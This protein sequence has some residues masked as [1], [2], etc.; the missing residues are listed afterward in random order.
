[1]ST[2]ILPSGQSQTTS[3]SPRR[4]YIATD[5][6]IKAAP[7]PDRYA[8]GWHVIGL[9]KQFQDG[10]PHEL[11]IFGTKLVV[12][13]GE[14]GNLNVLDGYCPHMGAS[15]GKGKIIGN[16]VSCAFHGWEWGG[17]GRC[18]NI[19]FS[20]R[21]PPRAKIK[22]WPTMIASDQLFVY[23]DPE[24]N[25]P[26]PEHAIPS[27]E[28]YDAG[29]CTPWHWE[30]ELMP[31]NC[32]ELIDNNADNTHFYYVHGWMVR[33]FKNIFEGHTSSQI[34]VYDARKDRAL[35][36]G[37][38][39]KNEDGFGMESSATYYG[40]AYMINKQ[41]AN[42]KGHEIECWLINAHYPVTP[43]SFVL[44]VGVTARKVPGLP[45][46][47]ALEIAAEYAKA[48]RNAFFQDVEIWRNKTR[49]DNPLLS[50]HDGP[51]YQLRR[52]YEQFY[53]DVK[54]VQPDMVE[55]FELEV[56]MT[57][58]MKYWESEQAKVHE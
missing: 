34:A 33:K 20:T 3:P 50:E 39:V 15:L 2:P 47:A 38:G 36:E 13:A 9:V 45:E 40:P 49:I 29:E 44:N 18:S 30:T 35:G 11:E 48:F 57:Q 8:R 58:P 56:D 12:F 14:D 7:P 32:R 46:E 27:I 28:A 23:N 16:S 52:W 22:S 54:D 37:D 24:G 31:T 55:R 17:N 5:Y 4:D 53:V 43:E 41:I 10:V 21:I 25:P 19:P 26:P 51:I 1:M 6:V 42:Y